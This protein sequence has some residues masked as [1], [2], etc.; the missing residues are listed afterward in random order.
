MLPLNSK[1]NTKCYV[2]NVGNDKSDKCTA[3]ATEM[4][5]FEAMD[6]M[7]LR[8]FRVVVIITTARKWSWVRVIGRSR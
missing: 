2:S 5:H 1:K 7:Q 3:I 6:V 8:S 4:H